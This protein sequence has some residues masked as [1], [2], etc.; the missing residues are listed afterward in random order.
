M[1]VEIQLFAAEITLG[2]IDAQIIDASMG[3]LGGKLKPSE[4][5]YTYF[6]AFFRAHGK[7]TDWQ[8]LEALGLKTTAL[9]T[10]EL[11]AVGGICI[12]DVE[13]LGEIEVEV[14]GIDCLIMN[15][16]FPEA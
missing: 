3:V 14:C 9:L 7:K 16:L 6:Q 8:G 12:T 15:E 2:T 4:V 10:G 1:S 13:G 5:Y 11:R